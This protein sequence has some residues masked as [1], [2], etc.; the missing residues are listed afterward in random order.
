M[1]LTIR[2]IGFVAISATVIISS[3]IWHARRLEAQNSSVEPSV[4]RMMALDKNKDG[5]LTRDEVSDP[6]LQ[7]LFNQIDT[8][9]SGAIT[10]AQIAAFFV[11]QAASMPAGVADGPGGF[12]GGP[13]GGPGGSGGRFGGQGSGPPRPGQILPEFLTNSLNLSADQKA[14]LAVL[15]KEV[16]DRLGKILTTTQKKQMSQFRGPG[17]LGGPGSG[18]G[19]GPGGPPPT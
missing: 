19:G 4:N 15:Q 11:K 6:R 3:G 18:P 2:V 13:G 16:D 8:A 1:R 9:K 10:R 14:K 12:P 17:G 5:K 7:A